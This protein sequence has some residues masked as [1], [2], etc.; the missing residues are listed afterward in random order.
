MAEIEDV[1]FVCINNTYRKC[2]D[3]EAT[4]LA[5]SVGKEKRN[6]IKYIFG[7]ADQRVVTAY[8]VK[9]WVK[10]TEFPLK[11]RKL[12]IFDNKENFNNRVAFIEDKEADRSEIEKFIGKIVPSSSKFRSYGGNAGRCGTFEEVKKLLL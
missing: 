11:T 8:V 1:I 9:G 12:D 7:V 4:L 10:A 5:W 3:D 6:N 2:Q